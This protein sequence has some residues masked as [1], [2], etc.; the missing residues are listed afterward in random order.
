MRPRA[1]VRAS[2]KGSKVLCGTVDSK[3]VDFGHGTIYAA[4]S[5]QTFGV[6]GH[7]YSNFLASTGPIVVIW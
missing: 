7:S 2:A 5:S 6:G 4:F 3:K 1:I